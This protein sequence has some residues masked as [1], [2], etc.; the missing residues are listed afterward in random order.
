MHALATFRTRR[1]GVAA[2]VSRAA[3]MGD[4][5]VSLG[6]ADDYPVWFSVSLHWGIA[7]GYHIAGDAEAPRACL[8]EGECETVAA[9]P[10]VYQPSG[11]RGGGV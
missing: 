5:G 7:V 6:H 8:S 4:R 3:P 11:H 1:R 10:W 9:S 2:S